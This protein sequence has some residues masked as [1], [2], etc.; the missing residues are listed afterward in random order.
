MTDAD[1]IEDIGGRRRRHT[2][3]LKYSCA[4][5]GRRGVDLAAGTWAVRLKHLL[6]M[7]KARITHQIIQAKP[8]DQAAYLND[9]VA[10]RGKLWSI[11]NMKLNYWKQLAWR[12]CT[13]PAYVQ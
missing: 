6:K 7:G 2:K 10:A 11:I 3:R 13:S 4:Y 12:L 8:E 9:W 1:A 5:K